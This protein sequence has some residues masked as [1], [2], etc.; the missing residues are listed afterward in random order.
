MK[1]KTV[2]QR[3]RYAR[4]LMPPRTKRTS[5]SYMDL[6]INESNKQL[7]KTLATLC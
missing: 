2:K 1:K 6:M 3:L 4:I 5:T 7:A